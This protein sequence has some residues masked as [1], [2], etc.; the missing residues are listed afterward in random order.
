MTCTKCLD[1]GFI[2]AIKRKNNYITTFRCTCSRSNKYS[3]KITRW[4]ESFSKDYDAD[5]K[6]QTSEPDY[7][8]KAANPKDFSLDDEAPF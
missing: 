5:F 7:K 3:E 2:V 8:V 1:S 6:K 4:N